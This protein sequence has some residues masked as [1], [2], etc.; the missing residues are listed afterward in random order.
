MKRVLVIGATG[1]IGSRFVELA[2]NIFE[3][4]PVDEKVLDITNQQAVEEYFSTT[5]LDAVVNFAAFT[6]VDAAEKERNDT[7]G[8]CYKLN[9]TGVENLAYASKKYNKFLVQISTDFVFSGTTDNPG[10][11]DELSPV[12]YELLP[13][14]GWYGWTKK[15]AEVKIE[16]AR[17]K[18]AIVRIVYPFS[19]GKYDLKLDYAKNFLKLY[20]D[21][22]LFPIFTDQTITLLYIE[23]L[24]NP[25]SKILEEE[26]Q[27]IFHIVS[28]DIATPFDFV[29]YLLSKARNVEG[30]V[31]K[32]S[33]EEFLKTPGRTPR[34]RLGG[35]K[36][37]I[38]QQK[39][40]M[41]FRT[42]R[43]MVDE[44]ASKL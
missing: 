23:D 13:S 29:E 6:N 9:V 5:Q 33:M 27:G 25:L 16:N 22:K 12:P 42:W 39:L 21:G 30:V 44:F 17:A 37:E 32:G 34:P 10:P 38:T 2:K 15:E 8:L 31:K 28:S 40:E 3:I 11:Y 18:S 19:F 14:M 7:K 26:L 20:D 24:I 1:L 35:L 41:K 4:I 43:E 36:T